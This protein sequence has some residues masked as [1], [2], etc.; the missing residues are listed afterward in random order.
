MSDSFA[1][2]VILVMV[3]AILGL[4]VLL[5]SGILP[6]RFKTKEPI[7]LNVFGEIGTDFCVIQ[8]IRPDE[9][10]IYLDKLDEQYFRTHSF[11]WEKFLNIKHEIRVRLQYCLEWNELNNVWYQTCCVHLSSDEIIFLTPGR[12]YVAENPLNCE[13]VQDVIDAC[14]L[15]FINWKDDLPPERPG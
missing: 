12:T 15:Q 5:V 3:V 11:P 1:L 7:I 6:L 4:L 9:C 13:P 8:Y 10:L 14:T 2:G